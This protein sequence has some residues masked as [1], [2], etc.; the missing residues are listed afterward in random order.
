VGYSNENWTEWEY[1][2]DPL[3]TDFYLERAEDDPFAFDACIARFGTTQLVAVNEADWEFSDN[4][5]Q[6]YPNPSST[7]FN[8]EIGE[9]KASQLLHIY[10]TTGEIVS[11][12]L[13]NSKALIHFDTR[14]MS[15]GLYLITLSGTPTKSIKLIVN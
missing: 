2:A 8:I 7:D 14:N 12:Q 3:S 4:S 13:V 1:D 15:S 6:V 9:L 5:L 10:N 11:C